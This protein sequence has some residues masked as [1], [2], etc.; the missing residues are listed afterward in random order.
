VTETG[1]GLVIGFINRLQVVITINYNT[2][3]NF[4]STGNP[5][6]SS[7]SISTCLHFPFPGNGSQQRNYHSHTLQMLHINQ[8]FYS[9]VKS[10]QGDEL[11]FSIRFTSLHFTYTSQSQPITLNSLTQLKSVTSNHTV[12]FSPATNLPR[13]SPTENYSWTS[14][15]LSY[16]PLIWHEGNAPSNGASVVASLLTRSRDPSPLVRHPNVYSCC[17][18]TRDVFT[19]ALRSNGSGATLTARKTPLSSTVA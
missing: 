2:V 13:L 14:F 12:R 19:S 7:Q 10:L 4:H 1:S 17:L 9:H 3:T 6:H 8:V 11:S 15:S 18:A 16:K 5:R